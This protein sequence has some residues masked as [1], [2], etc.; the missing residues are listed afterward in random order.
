M[1]I[2]CGGTI[3]YQTTN[4]SAV[5]R[6]IKS[7]CSVHQRS[8]DRRLGTDADA[9]PKSVGTEFCS[10]SIN[11]YITPCR[12]G[13]TCGAM[14]T[15]SHASVHIYYSVALASRVHHSGWSAI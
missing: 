11:G 6:T 9:E 5:V 3:K 8:E 1:Q 2:R 7:T 10:T 4:A 12:W 14:S 15:P 13:Q